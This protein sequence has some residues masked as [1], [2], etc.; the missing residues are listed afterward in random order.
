MLIKACLNI[1]ILCV[2]YASNTI[3]VQFEKLVGGAGAAEAAS[4]FGS[5]SQNCDP[6]AISLLVICHS[7][8]N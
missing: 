3:V 6:Y 5:Q 7:D 1:A 8:D 4:F 2:V